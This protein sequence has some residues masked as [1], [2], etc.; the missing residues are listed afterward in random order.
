MLQAIAEELGGFVPY[1]G[2]PQYAS[3]LLQPLK[4]LSEVEET[5]VRE[6][7]VDSL[8]KV[9][10]TMGEADIAEHFFPLLKVIPSP[11]PCR[12][13]VQIFLVQCLSC[14]LSARS[15]P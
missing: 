1:V 13:L 4:T 2:G 5:V 6:T 8:C 15:G 11:P 9:G 10:S 12:L 3:T 14:L 7:A